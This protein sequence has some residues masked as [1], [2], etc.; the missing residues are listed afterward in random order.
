MYFLSL[1]WF[2]FSIGFALLPGVVPGILNFLFSIFACLCHN[3]IFD[4]IRE[5]IKKSIGDCC[6]TLAVMPGVPVNSEELLEHKNNYLY[7]ILLALLELLAVGA[8]VNEME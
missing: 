4:I 3:L 7:T 1:H 8:V 5:D 6:D 2:F